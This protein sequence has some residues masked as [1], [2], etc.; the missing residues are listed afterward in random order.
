[1]HG[2]ILGFSQPGQSSPRFAH[3]L[4]NK[5]H[6]GTFF[7]LLL[8]LSVGFFLSY[9]SLY[10]IFISPLVCTHFFKY[11]CSAVILFLQF[12]HWVFPSLLAIYK[13]RIPSL[14]KLRKHF[15][16]LCAKRKSSYF[17]RIVW[18]PS[19]PYLEKCLHPTTGWEV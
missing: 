10:L 17:F 13:T 5:F 18:L 15:D 12:L 7:C 8:F 6:L 16:I 4:R 2:S 3:H 19:I 1:M 9:R 11:L 14:T